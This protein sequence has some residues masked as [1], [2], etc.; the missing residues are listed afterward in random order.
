M[1]TSLYRLCYNQRR[2][3]LSSA[4]EANDPQTDPRTKDPSYLLR[5]VRAHLLGLV[6]LPDWGVG[7][8]RSHSPVAPDSPGG[9]TP[10]RQDNA[11]L[12]DEE[13]PAAENRQGLLMLYQ[14]VLI[15]AR[16]QRHGLRY[17]ALE[18]R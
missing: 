2:C 4:L 1:D 3:T 10:R 16:D 17:Q 9:G 14:T 11:M 5:Q 18:A 7:L 15:V 12:P 13:G 6:T 8:C